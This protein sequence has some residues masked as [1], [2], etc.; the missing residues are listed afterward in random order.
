SWK[1]DLN[2]IPVRIIPVEQHA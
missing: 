1:W 2:T